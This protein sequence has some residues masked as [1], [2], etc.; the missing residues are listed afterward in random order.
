MGLLS[1]LIT[2]NAGVVFGTTQDDYELSDF[3]R[4]S[5]NVAVGGEWWW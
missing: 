5:V 3:E 2:I 1:T 4:V